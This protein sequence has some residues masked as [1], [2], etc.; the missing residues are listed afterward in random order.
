MDPE[1]YGK[2][3]D[4]EIIADQQRTEHIVKN[5][6]NTGNEY[7]ITNPNAVSDGDEKG[8]GEGEDGSVGTI[9][10]IKTRIELLVKNIYNE[11]FQYDSTVYMLFPINNEATVLVGLYFHHI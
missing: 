11:N 9:T 6:Y 3:S 4:L 7:S 2:N 10:D 5:I 1:E 8:R